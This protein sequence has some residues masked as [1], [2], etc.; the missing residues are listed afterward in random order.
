MV[1]QSVL[2]RAGLTRAVEIRYNKVAR[3]RNEKVSVQFRESLAISTRQ[4]QEQ[5]KKSGRDGVWCQAHLKSNERLVENGVNPGSA[6]AGGWKWKWRLLTSTYLAQGEAGSW[7]PP[8][9]SLQWLVTMFNSTTGSYGSC[10]G[11]RLDLRNTTGL[12]PDWEL[13][14][15]E[16]RRRRYRSGTDNRR[17]SPSQ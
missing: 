15:I 2:Y 13:N 5:R 17:H 3:D 7:G 1:L 8:R 16:A 14:L 11:F 10:D 9:A 6:G 4:E 12:E